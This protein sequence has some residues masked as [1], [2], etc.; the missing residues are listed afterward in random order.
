MEQQVDV[1]NGDNVTVTE[2]VIS[3]GSKESPAVPKRTPRMLHESS[4]AT[5]PF[6][7]NGGSHRPPGFVASSLDYKANYKGGMD[8]DP[9]NGSVSKLLNPKPS[10]RLLQQR[11]QEE[12]QQ[13]QQQQQQEAKQKYSAPPTRA[14]GNYGPPPHQIAT[15]EDLEHMTEDQLY[16]L[17][18]EEP[19]LYRSLLKSTGETQSSS[20][21]SDSSGKRRVNSDT[22]SHKSTKRN[23]NAR[24]GE[25]KEIPYI[26]WL[27]LLAL[28]GLGLYQLRKSIM[29]DPVKQKRGSTASNSGGALKGKGGKQRK[30]KDKKDKLPNQQKKFGS[31]KG[32]ELSKS[33]QKKS[34][35]YAVKT[36]SVAPESPPQK[37][38]EK[39][40][41]LSEDVTTTGE[42]DADGVN[43]TTPPEANAVDTTHVTIMRTFNSATETERDGEAWQTVAKFREAKSERNG[44]KSMDSQVS[45]MKSKSATTTETLRKGESFSEP[46]GQPNWKETVISATDAAPAENHRVDSPLSGNRN[47]VTNNTK[48]KKKKTKQSKSLSTNKQIVVSKRETE[49]TDD[50]AALAQQLQKQEESRAKAE[51]NDE[52]LQEETWEEVKNKKKRG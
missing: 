16:R 40:S 15:L 22:R 46:N 28:M 50:D 13:K 35:H 11:Q 26:Q 2:S 17:F 23:L 27:V 18:M 9:T 37:K 1:D 42:D 10:S 47:D 30:Q 38:K 21:S 45:L 24:F 39:N 3:D 7:S 5:S 48:T 6:T 12:N 33:A 14:Q 29:N 19:E 41:K 43:D 44:T 4:F 49:S 31:D 8:N 51:T 34:Q 25:D 20:A 52:V 36:D 32:Q